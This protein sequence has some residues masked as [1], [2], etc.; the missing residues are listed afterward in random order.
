[1]KLRG[2]VEED[3][4]NFK[5]PSMVLMMPYCDWKCGKDLCQNSPLA[6]AP[7][8]E[9][10]IED[11]AVR[12]RKNSLTSAIVLSGLEPMID[13]ETIYEIVEAFR[14]YC[15]DYIVIY[16]GYEEH[17]IYPEVQRLQE[18]FSNIIMKYGRYIPNQEP[19]FDPVLGVNLASDSQYAE[20]I[21]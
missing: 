5:K 17:E 11:L 3:F 18:D 10:K 9:Y 15:A 8:I 19:H 21:S 16:T 13:F 6:K 20:V 7:I 1:M 4:V 12:Y 14:K 2:L